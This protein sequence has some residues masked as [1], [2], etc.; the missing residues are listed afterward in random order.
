[1]QQRS[2]Q[3]Q[4]LGSEKEENS[5]Q[6][7]KRVALK[8]SASRG[9]ACSSQLQ[10]SLLKLNFGTP[11]KLAIAAALEAC[12][13]SAARGLFRNRETILA[14]WPA[15]SLPISGQLKSKTIVD[16]RSFRRV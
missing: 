14:F 10:Q 16:M 1:M 15:S 6:S 13:F 3:L 7:E 2:K 12:I 5:L 4:N 9:N 8:V 11:G